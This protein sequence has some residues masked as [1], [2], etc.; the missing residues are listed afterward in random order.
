VAID[1][2][3]KLAESDLLAGDILLHRP[4]KAKLH[5]KKISQVTNSPY[6]HAS[7]FLG[8][9]KIVEAVV[10]GIRRRDLSDV[11]EPPFIVGV[12]RSQCGFG[13]QRVTLLQ[14]FISNLEK[15]SSK[16]DFFGAVKY[17]STRSKFQNEMLELLSKRFGEFS[18]DEELAKQR[19]FCSALV[20]A[21]Y[22][23]VGIIG[24]SAQIAYPPNIH[25]PGDLV[26]D[27]TFG[28]VLGFLVSEDVQFLDDD[29]LLSQTMWKDQMS[30]KWW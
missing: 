30:I 23:V 2:N 24:K 17:A 15:S 11:L 1:E 22:T 8:D 28:W 27:P 20:V 10:S 29:P 3:L 19:Y 16:Y 26:N 25:A 14:N 6:T 5:Q 4:T 7:I 9:G 13:K 21:C 12:L 18:S